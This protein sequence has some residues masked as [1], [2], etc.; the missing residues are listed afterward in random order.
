M[1]QKGCAD[2]ERR[3]RSDGELLHMEIYKCLYDNQM[4]LDSKQHER[5]YM[6]LLFTPKTLSSLTGCGDW[7]R[8]WCLSHP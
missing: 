8:A 4:G 2:W 1:V 3:A 5:H 7:Y 6:A